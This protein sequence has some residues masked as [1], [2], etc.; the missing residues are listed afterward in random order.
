MMAGMGAVDLVVGLL[1]ATVLFVALAGRWRL[2]YPIVLLLVGLALALV[3]GLP[4][5]RLDPDVILVIFLP[6]LIHAA[7]LETS[8]QELRQ[9]LSI[10]L[11][12]AVG[13]VLATIGAVAVVTHALVPDLP[14]AAALVL[15]AVVSPP[16]AVSATQIAAAVGLPRR[17]VTILGGEGLINDGTALTAYNLAVTAA[18]TGGVTVAAVLGRFSYAVVVGVVLGLAV[19]FVV[20]RLLRLLAD[21]ILENTLLLVM[22]FAAYLPAEAL[23]ASGVLAVLTTGLAYV[24]FGSREV[25]AAGRLQQRS[26]WQLVEFVL[27]ALSFLLIGLQ[28]RSVVE[29]LGDASVLRLTAQAAAVC[30]TV[31]VLRLVWVLTTGRAAARRVAPGASRP[32]RGLLV[33]G[34]SGMRGVLT[35]ATAL[36]IP[37]D[38]PQRPLLVFLAFSVILVTLLGQGLTLGP[39]AKRLGVLTQDERDVVQQV[40]IRLRTAERARARLE[41][42]L[43][44][45]DL[46][47]EVLTR[48]ASA[49]DTRVDRLQRLLDG[50]Q[51]AV[52]PDDPVHAA[53]VADR[54]AT[55]RLKAELIG[56]EQTELARLVDE[57]L[58]QRTADAV[59][60]RLDVD[61][62]LPGT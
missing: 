47:E 14:W 12:L 3:P 61:S 17:L 20:R 55:Q 52:D 6:P 15:G 23:G 46:P 40:R 26:F 37:D 7:A 28:L 45:G 59:R 8:V 9:D 58:D 53:K 24:R 41:E 34:W 50:E 35:L 39:L 25:T 36:A 43:E 27:T 44:R 30:G 57:G 42:H 54:A 29:D 56:V 4:E 19:A 18:V 5:V 33:A 16:D 62:L 31:I 38:V 51:G 22:P 60:R 32:S 2:P 48:F 11:R 10:I 13:L 49:Y 1:L 21:P